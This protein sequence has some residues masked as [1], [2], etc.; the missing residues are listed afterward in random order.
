MITVI[1]RK[2]KLLLL[3]FHPRSPIQRVIRGIIHHSLNDSWFLRLL[4]VSFLLCYSPNRGRKVE[5]LVPSGAKYHH[6]PSGRLALTTSFSSSSLTTPTFSTPNTRTQ[7]WWNDNR[8]R[9]YGVPRPL[10]TEFT[11]EKATPILLEELNVMQWPTWSTAGSTK[12]QVGIKSP[13]KVYEGNELSYILE[14]EMEIIPQNT[15]IPVVVQAGDFVT[16]PDG[17]ACYWYVKKVINKHWYIY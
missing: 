15:G 4:L 12:Y 13:L 17:F 10:H 16:F 7:S 3:L 11:V 1:N 2:N 14:G 8:M 9:C 6:Y 5:A